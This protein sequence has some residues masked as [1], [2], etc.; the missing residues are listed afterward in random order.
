MAAVAVLAV[1]LHVTCTTEL[2]RYRGESGRLRAAIEALR[3]RRPPD[4]PARDW[5]DAVMAGGK[6][7][8]N[9]LNV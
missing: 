4:L 9:D 7:G 5:D 2:H 8:Q 1:L 3:A 6:R